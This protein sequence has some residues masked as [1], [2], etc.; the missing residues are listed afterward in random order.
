[1]SNDPNRCEC[2]VC[3]DCRGFSRVTQDEE[4]PQFCDTCH[5]TGM[6]FI[7][8]WCCEEEPCGR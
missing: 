3:A 6:A 1:M 4:D 8:G 2:V 5:G 7:C